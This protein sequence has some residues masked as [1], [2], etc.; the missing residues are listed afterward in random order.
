MDPL[1]AAHILFLGL[2]GGLVLVEIAFE[3]QMFRGK[4]DEKSIAGLHRIT[5][6][7][8]EL[9]ILIAVLATGW[10]LWKRTGFD[11]E[12]M[13]KVIFGLGAVLANAVCYVVVE[14]RASRALHMADSDDD[15]PGLRRFSIVLA[16]SI[17]PGV[18][19][20]GVALF[21]GGQRIGWW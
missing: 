16:S 7:F 1:G 17:A 13:P 21:L 5:D 6:R 18:L 4:M 12:L 3:L 9:P 19:S 20:A 11:H 8:I 15:G 14:M 10:L 2:W